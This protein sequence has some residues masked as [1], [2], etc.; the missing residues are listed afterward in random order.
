M[1]NSLNGHCTHIGWPP[2]EQVTALRPNEDTT[3]IVGQK[4]FG[5]KV[6]F[7]KKLLRPVQKDFEF[8]K[9]V[10][11]VANSLLAEGK[12]RSWG[13]WR[14]RRSPRRCANNEEA[15]LYIV[16][17]LRISK[18]SPWYNMLRFNKGCAL[19]R[20]KFPISDLR[21]DLSRYYKINTLRHLGH[22]CFALRKTRYTRL[23][24]KTLLSLAEATKPGVN[25]M[26]DWTWPAI[27]GFAGCVNMRYVAS[28]IYMQ[29][30]WVASSY[31]L[32]KSQ[33]YSASG[34]SCRNHGSHHFVSRWFMAVFLAR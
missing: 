23:P 29:P 24:M 17:M 31:A 4:A 27:F 7:T 13:R 33:S 32:S 20:L 8:A 34:V 1:S 15:C 16:L 12:I 21:A 6:M 11:D 22:T 19:S 10:A 26:W 5:K 2:G 28:S 3:L 25:T 14:L 9:M 30:R 18:N